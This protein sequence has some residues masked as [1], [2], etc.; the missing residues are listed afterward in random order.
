MQSFSAYGLSLQS[1]VHLPELIAHEAIP[2]ITISRGS[3]GRFAD[4]VGRV[5]CVSITSDEVVLAWGSIASVAIRRG[6]EMVLDAAEDIAEEILRLLVLGPA[7]GVLLHQRGIM[8]LHASVVAQ[9][10]TAVAFIGWKGAGKSTTAASLCARGYTLLSDDILAVE[11]STPADIRVLPGFPQM[12]LWPDA[13]SAVGSDPDVLPRLVP[14]AAKRAY[15]GARFQERSCALR[16]IYVLEFGD[17]LRVEP[18]GGQERVIELVRHSY[19][20][21]FLGNPAATPLHFRQCVDLA[22]RV[23]IRRLIRPRDLD[24]L[25]DLAELIRRDAA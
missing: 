1:S 18:V 9:S 16:R 24:A 21:R 2:T 20:I 6:T 19:A 7:L 12:K 10:D 22:A 5:Q 4:D 14:G 15:T 25:D 3:V 23:P 11:P 8:T 13:A 17:D